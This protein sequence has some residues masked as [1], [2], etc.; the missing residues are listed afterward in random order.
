MQGAAHDTIEPRWGEVL[1]LIGNAKRAVCKGRR[2]AYRSY[3]SGRDTLVLLG[4]AFLEPLG[5]RQLTVA[6]RLRGLWEL[7]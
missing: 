2:I 5:Y 7:T 3:G 4:W 1:D 6:W